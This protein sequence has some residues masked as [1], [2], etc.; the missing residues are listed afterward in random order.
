MHEPFGETRNLPVGR[1]FLVCAGGLLAAIL[2]VAILY[3]ARDAP[4]G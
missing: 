4:A 1:M 3:R 2:I